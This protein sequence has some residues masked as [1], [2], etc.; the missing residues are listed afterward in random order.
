MEAGESGRRGRA[1]G[2]GREGLPR[3]G[4]EKACAI[5]HPACPGFEHAP[6]AAHRPPCPCAIL[7]APRP[8]FVHAPGGTHPP[9]ARVRPAARARTEGP[10]RPGASPRRRRSSS[11]GEPAPDAPPRHPATN[12]L[13]TRRRPGARRSGSAVY[14]P[15]RHAAWGADAVGWW[16]LPPWPS[17]WTAG[18]TDRIPNCLFARVCRRS[19]GPLA[20]GAPIPPR[21]VRGVRHGVRP[22]PPRSVAGASGTTWPG[23]SAPRGS[24]SPP[25]LREQHQH[26]NPEGS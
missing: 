2:A 18:W 19:A 6:R 7:Y 14:G 3:G 22:S 25:D 16:P 15:R 23:R 9:A 5:P 24:A 20:V 8:G 10:A 13:Q 26:G 12:S 4:E 1:G 11:P 17:D 21:A